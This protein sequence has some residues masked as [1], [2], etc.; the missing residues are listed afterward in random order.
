MQMGL[1]LSAHSPA[2]LLLVYPRHHLPQ[3]RLWASTSSVEF[4]YTAGPAPFDDGLGR[5]LATRYST[6][7]ASNATWWTDSNGRDMVKRVRNA[8]PDWNYTA[9]E[10]IAGN[11][12][13]VTAAITT[14]DA[15]SGLSLTVTT[16]RSQGGASLADGS[17]GA[18]ES[19]SCAWHWTRVLLRAAVSPFALSLPLCRAPRLQAPPAR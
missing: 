11:F 2:L 7:L 12:Y 9:Y 6:S 16:D 17:I 3:V 19:R 8:R 14:Q 4:E 5:E 10:P 1:L 18:S 13:P 15:S